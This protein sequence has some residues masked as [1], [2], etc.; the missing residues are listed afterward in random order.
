MTKKLQEIRKLKGLSQSELAAQANLNVRMIQ[1]Y[2]QEVKNLNNA[3]I[4]I[5]FKLCLTL[6]C[7]LEDILTENAYID[8]IKDYYNQIG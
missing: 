1:H 8:L 3:R 2:E 4:D 5:I 6:D 7:K